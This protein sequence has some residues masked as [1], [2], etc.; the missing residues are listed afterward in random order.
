MSDTNVVPE[1]WTRET[2]L[3]TCTPK[4]G[5]GDQNLEFA[6][7]VTEYDCNIGRRATKIIPNAKGGRITLNLPL[8]DGYLEFTGVF[9]GISATATDTNSSLR[10]YFYAG[11]SPDLSEPYSKTIANSSYKWRCVV[12]HTD[13][14]NATSATSATTNEYN[15]ERHTFKHC[16]LEE[17]NEKWNPTDGKVTKVRFKLVPFDRDGTGQYTSESTEGNALPSIGNY[18]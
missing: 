15:A 13:D 16:D 4:D 12:M 14:P 2:L 9:I 7:R 8:E 10:Q 3:I 11:A 17:F 18:T 6:A 5:T 1:G